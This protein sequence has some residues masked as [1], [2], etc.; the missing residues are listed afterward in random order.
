MVSRGTFFLSYGSDTLQKH[1]G[2]CA[3]SLRSLFPTPWKA[4]SISHMSKLRFKSK[5]FPSFTNPDIKNLVTSS[6]NSSAG[7]WS[8][9]RG[10]R[11][12]IT[13]LP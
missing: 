7:G 1:T 8:G 13:M 12:K 11:E 4:L 9:S 6:C 3:Y 5:I 10:Y 2:C